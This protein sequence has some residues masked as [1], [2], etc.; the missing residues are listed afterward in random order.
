[1]RVNRSDV[2][3]RNTRV[4][5]NLTFEHFQCNA[6]VYS[7]L[8]GFKVEIIFFPFN[9]IKLAKVTRENVISHCGM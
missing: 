1:M 2:N 8:A 4:R 6:N 3:T 9:L 5:V 7:D